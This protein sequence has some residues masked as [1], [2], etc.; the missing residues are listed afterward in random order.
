M[1]TVVVEEKIC[2]I[3]CEHMKNN[4]LSH[5]YLIET[6]DYMM[7]NDLMMRIVKSILCFKQGKH[8]ELDDCNICKLIDSNQY[9]D[10]KFIYPQGNVIKKEQ[11]LEIKKAFKTTSLNQYRIYVIF[12]SEYLNA[13][14]ANTILKFLEEP[15]QGV[16]AFLVAKNRYQV[17]E[18]LVSRCQILTLSNCLD[19]ELDPKVYE[20]L[21]RI[22]TNSDFYLDFKD[23]LTLYM[24]DK[25]TSKLLLDDLEFYLHQL[26]L[27]KTNSISELKCAELF[28]NLS[29]NSIIKYISILEEEKEK[30]IYN[31]N[32]R[33]WL[34]HLLVRFLEVLT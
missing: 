30:L 10:L 8:S 27:F 18:T 34:D 16:I 4:R 26:L 12:D 9:A 13:S 14:A 22:V 15:E 32:Y 23:I 19:R 11:L 5:A 3:I 17:L 25:N 20:F 2:N 28:T 24:P 33:L 21:Q 6:G 7:V 1:D 31:I 29:K